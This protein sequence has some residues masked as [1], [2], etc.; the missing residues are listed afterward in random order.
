MNETEPI[1][2]DVSKST[3]TYILKNDKTYVAL[4]GVIIIGSIVGIITFGLDLRLC[5]IPIMLCA[6][7]YERV[8]A[9]IKRE[10]T[11][12]FG[13]SIGFDY[14]ETSTMESVNGKLFQTGHSQ[15]LFD[16][17]S[18]TQDNLPMR[19]FSF[20]FTIGY[21][22]NSHTYSYTVFEVTLNNPVPNIL[23]FS[24]EQTTAVSDW[25]SGDETVQLEGDFNKYFKLRVPKGREQEAYQI[26]TPDVMADLIDRARD[27]S[28]E[29]SGNHLYIYAPKVITKRDELQNMFNLVTYMDNL[30]RKN[31]SSVVI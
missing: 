8:Q 19:I 22:K 27:F 23:L 31:A 12:Q 30:F 3:E 1:I 21:G 7:G 20:R 5:A 24:N 25:F 14:A 16:V 17:L 9:K 26:F 18:G 28:F 2:E 11:K 15:S 13:A 6:F 10:F 4:F 29:F